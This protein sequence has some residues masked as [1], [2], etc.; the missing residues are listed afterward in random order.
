MGLALKLTRALSASLPQKPEQSRFV[1]N[2]QVNEAGLS[3]IRHF[4]GLSLKPYHDAVGY[5]T[6]G[7]GRL[8]SRV[9]WIDLGQFPLITHEEAAVWLLEDLDKV[10]RGLV[11]LFPIPLNDNEFA[12]LASFAFN[13]G[14][15]AL[16]AS[17]LRRLLL[18]GQ[19]LDA[20]EQFL[21]WDHAGGRKLAGLTRRRTAE[22]ALFLA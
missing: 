17:T 6:Q 16:E 8:L 15:G 10:S 22:R 18:R 21:R 20:A 13:L 11:R 9:R 7:Y 3:L 12:A 1:G 14:L 5:A 4:E 19:R 2:R